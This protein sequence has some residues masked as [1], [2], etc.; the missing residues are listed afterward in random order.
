MKRFLAT[1]GLAAGLVFASALPAFAHTSSVV[2]DCVDGHSL[3]KYTV[4]VDFPKAGPVVVKSLGSPAVG[5]VTG[6]EVTDGFIFL[7]PSPLAIGFKWTGDNFQTSNNVTVT[8]ACSPG[9]PGPKGDTGATGPAGPQGP[10]GPSGTSGT[11]GPAGPAGPAGVAGPAGPRG[12][13]GLEGTNGADGVD[14]KPG[15]NGVNGLDGFNGDDGKP[16]ETGN[17][18]YSVC[19]DGALAGLGVIPDC[20]G[21]LAPAGKDGRD[22]KDA[23]G[24]TSATTAPHPVDPIPGT[25]PHTG[26]A[27]LPLVLAA[28]AALISGLVFRRLSKR[29]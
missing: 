14:G 7:A 21:H 16:G 6:D 2:G 29:A 27:T 8:S 1:L 22:G 12:Y 11:A 5:L 23:S 10:A 24:A 13:G 25:L 3:V 9:S 20:S 4:H 19:P 17:P 15:T 28:L 26:A 18:G